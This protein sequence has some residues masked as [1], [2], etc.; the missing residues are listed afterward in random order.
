MG[1]KLEIICVIA[2]L[3]IFLAINLYLAATDS[4]TIDEAPHISSG[5]SY[6]LTGDYRMNPEHPPLLKLLAAIPLLFYG[7]DLPIN[8]QSW[9]NYNE[10]DFGRQF[11]YYNTKP[12][13]TIIFLAR[14]FPILLGMA[15]GCFIYKWAKE[16]F[17]KKPGLFALFLYVLSPEFLGHGHL[18]TT[19]V[20][21]AFFFLLS[22]YY[23]GR[24]LKK[25]L[26]G[27][28]FI[29][30]IVFA[31]AMLT[32]YS[33]VILIPILGCLYFIHWLINKDKIKKGLITLIKV[34]FVFLAVTSLL[35]VFLY[36]FEFKKAIDDPRVQ[37]LYQERSVIVK[38]GT[39]SQLP[40]YLRFTA[41]FA[42]PNIPS[43][44]FLLKVAEKLPL[45][46][47]SYWRGF[48][49]VLSHNEMGHGTVL[50]GKYSLTGWW[51]YFIVA[52]LVKTPLTVLFLLLTAVIFAVIKI[53][54]SAA[55]GS[56]PIW[57]RFKNLKFDYYLIKVPPLIYFLWSLTSHINLG[58]RHILPIYPFIF[59]GVSYLAN[60]SFNNRR[61]AN[62]YKIVLAA[63]IIFYLATNLKVF[64]N[65]LSYFN[66]AVGGPA[67]G[68]KYLLDSNLDWGQDIK[69]LKNYLE[70][71]NIKEFH[72]LLLGSLVKSYYLKDG[73]NMPDNAWVEKNGAEKGYYVISANPFFDP[74][75]TF[76]W[77][78]K[79][80]PLARIGYSIYIYKL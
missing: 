75:W 36:Q 64:P 8:H 4:Q 66:E 51:Y 14:L 48:F 29:A 41:K 74:T 18:V 30:A 56:Q 50:L 57:Q 37:K 11:L 78:Q 40:P 31:L 7:P 58:I 20:S 59:I 10:W 62:M 1:K 55:A 21:I 61:A 26:T 43:G 42:D 16:L 60:L 72:S 22:I 68:H 35:T 12:A 69:R 49:S 24:Y 67:Q 19:D 54:K 5:Y 38:K 65:Y 47:Y 15:L 33:A 28:L 23:F 3:G 52:F 25:P 76:Q 71:N 63:L 45:P 53:K 46:A 9:A 39:L 73:I 44:R 80:A 27:N 13:D 77:L 17:G 2:L 32:K 79:Y 34:F 70:K 6:F